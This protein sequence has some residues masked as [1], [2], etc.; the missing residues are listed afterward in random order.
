[1]HASLLMVL[2]A[3][4]CAGGNIPLIANAG[5]DIPRSEIQSTK[6]DALRGSGVSAFRLYNYYDVVLSDRVKSLYW[7]TI[8]AENDY[9]PGMYS[10]GFRLAEKEDVNSGARARYWLEKADKNGEPLARGILRQL[11]GPNHKIQ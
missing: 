6:A 7:V 9:P 8:S 1:M 2:A 5:L 4:V 10:L 11:D 3:S